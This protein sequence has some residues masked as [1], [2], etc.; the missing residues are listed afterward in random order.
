MRGVAEQG[1]A[2]FLSQP[3]SYGEPGATVDRGSRA[4]KMSPISWH[5]IDASGDIARTVERARAILAGAT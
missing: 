3:A 4:F 2:A 5:R 1:M